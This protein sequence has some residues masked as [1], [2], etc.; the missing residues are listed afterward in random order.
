LF[1][2]SNQM[3]AG[4]AFAVVTTILKTEQIPLHESKFIPVAA[5]AAAIVKG[6]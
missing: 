6:Q 4:I 5:S 3:L 1:G 2:I